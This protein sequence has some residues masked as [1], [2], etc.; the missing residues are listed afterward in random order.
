MKK[1]SKS[2]RRLLQLTGTTLGAATL[3]PL[4]ASGSGRVESSTYKIEP[5]QEHSD[6]SFFDARQRQLVD[7]LTETMIPADSHSGG[8]KAAKVVDHIDRV[9]RESLDQDRR[10]TWLDGLKLIEA[11]SERSC[12]KSFVEASSEQRIAI[13]QALSDN[14]EMTELLEIRFFNE[15]K[16]LTVDGYYTSKTGI[17]DELEYKGNTVLDEFVGCKETP[18]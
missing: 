11:M 9:L 3:L 18:S 16:R 6:K 8:A 14:I 17:L 13:L 5:G 2:R 15:L 12:G 10:Q 4:R 1:V 7:E